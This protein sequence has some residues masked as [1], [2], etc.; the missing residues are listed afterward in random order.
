[1]LVTTAAPHPDGPAARVMKRL[2]NSDRTIAWLHRKT[3]IKYK[4]LH[5]QL[6]RNPHTLTIEN[7]IRIADAFDV[8]LDELMADE[9]VDLEQAVV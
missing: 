2:T 4:T 1:M 7:S 9:D 8:T 5:T 6:K 3:G